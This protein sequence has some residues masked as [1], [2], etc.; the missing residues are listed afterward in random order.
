MIERKRL[1][2]IPI[3]KPSRDAWLA[4]KFAAFMLATPGLFFTITAG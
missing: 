4:R 3:V 2:I 1:P